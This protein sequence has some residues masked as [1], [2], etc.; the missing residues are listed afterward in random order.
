MK[1]GII[2][3]ASGRGSRM[4]GPVPKQ[5]AL[6][7]GRP[8]LMHTIEKFHNALKDSRIILVIPSSELSLWK[9]LCLEYN[10]NI[11]HDITFGGDNRFDSVKNGLKRASY[12]NIIGIHD[13]VRPLVTEKVIT[14]TK[15]TA[16]QYGCAIP[17]VPVSDSLRRYT[18][19]ENKIV[20]RSGLYA[21]QTPQFFKKRIIMDSYDTEFSPEFTDDASVAEK[22]G[23]AIHITDGDPLNIKLTTPADMIIAE[24][25]LSAI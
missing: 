11:P 9:K 25:I 18:D 23:Y 24:A 7:K 19:T 5:F 14:S 6:L 8:V 16:E 13:G 4:G 21:V 2:I 1:T 22:K 12:C 17:A 10:F 3:V 15:L 20:D